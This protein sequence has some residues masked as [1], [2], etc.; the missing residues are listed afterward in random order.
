MAST[1]STNLGI[2]LIGTGDQAGTWGTTTNTNLGT[3]IEQAISGYTTQAITDGVDTVIT[4]PNGATGV[5]RNMYLELTGTLTAARNLIVPTNKKLYF[6][7]NNTTG[8]YAVT[9]KVSGQTG[10]SVPNGSK[11]ILVSNGTDVVSA[12]TS[13]AISV[14]T[15][16]GLAGTST[17]GVTP[18]L[19]L[20]TTATGVLKGNGTA[21]SAAVSGTDYAPATSGTSILKGNGSGGFNSA[22]S[23]TDY[24]PATSGTSILKGNGAGGFSNATS[25][26]DYAP[27]T[28]G[29]SILYGNGSGGFSNVTIGSNL[30]F[31]GGTL[32]APSPGGMSLLTSITPSGTNYPNTTTNTISGLPTAKTY[33]VVYAF[34]GVAA[35]SS[36]FGASVSDG[37][38]TAL[39]GNIFGG[40]VSAGSMSGVLQIYNVSGGA[41]PVFTSSCDLASP[42]TSVGF[43]APS[44]Q[45][46]TISLSFA[47]TGN[48]TIY[49]YGIN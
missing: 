1:Y 2:E 5:A 16:N 7:Y 17:S 25:G 41:Y 49:V 29:T 19:T 11:V 8:G 10:V 27:A 42:K 3:L 24:A 48:G 44:G 28:S 36:G 31:V 6:I 26:T 20:S 23:G 15:A 4:I 45:I 13:P 18:T 37:T 38:T 14:A 22:A 30:T 33:I 46:T 21:I 32:A 9:V 12:T 43:A 34:V 39:L 35:S 47:F 40:G